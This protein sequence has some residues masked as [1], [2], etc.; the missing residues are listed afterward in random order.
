MHLLTVPGGAVEGKA[1]D[2]ILSDAV[3][4]VVIKGGIRSG[5]GG[6]QTGTPTTTG[7]EAVVPTTMQTVT[8]TPSLAF[9]GFRELDSV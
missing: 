8:A 9:A 7:V 2:W 6:G 3:Q 4:G 1:V 5:V